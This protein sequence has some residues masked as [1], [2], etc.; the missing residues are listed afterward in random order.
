LKVLSVKDV[1]VQ[2]GGLNAVDDVSFD[3]R[4]G[5]ITGLIGPNGAG[6]T[7]LFDAIC[8]LVPTTSGVIVLGEHDITKMPPYLRAGRGLGR[9]FQDGRLFPSLTVEECISTALASRIPLG[10]TVSAMLS[11]PT[12]RSRTAEARAR[13]DEIINMTGLATYAE[14]FV[15]DLSTGTRRIVDLACALAHRPTV[16]LLDEPSSGIAQ[17]E[18][19]ALGPLIKGIRERSDCTML[20]I[21]HDIPL[22]TSISDELLVME[23]GRLIARGHPKEVIEHPEVIRAYI[24]AARAPVKI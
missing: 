14:T 2:F 21:E 18:V 3:I 1:S 5:G 6:K 17:R 23:T 9:S 13:T 16:L 24:G 10:S 4:P 22:V 8:G 15:R 19:E 12:A 11:G 7:T 20:L